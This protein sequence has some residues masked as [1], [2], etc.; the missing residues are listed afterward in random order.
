MRYTPAI[1]F[2]LE[3]GRALAKYGVPAHR[4]EDTM[5]LAARHFGVKGEFFSTPTSIMATFRSDDDASTSVL[6]V[7]DSDVDLAKMIALD[8][9]VENLGAREGPEA[10]LARVREIDE[11]PVPYRRSLTVVSFGLV[12]G[13]AA[14]FFGGG[15]AEVGVATGIGVVIGLM[16]LLVRKLPAGSRGFDLV[17]AFVASM[18]AASVSH[19]I[20]PIAAYVATLAGLI[21]LIPGLTLTTAMSELATRNLVSGAARLTAAAIVFL[22]LIFGVALA[23]RIETLIWGASVAATATP[24]PPWT[25]FVALLVCCAGLVVLFRAPMSAAPGILLAAGLGLAGARWGG[26]TLG[27]DIGIFVGAYLV[28]VTANVYARLA[29]RPSAVLMLPGLLLLV[30]GSIGFRSLAEL[31]ERD[32]LAGVSSAFATVLAAVSIVAGLLMANITVRPKRLL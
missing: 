18:I 32:P 30:P 29:K 27:G 9:L 19:L 5:A 3:L 4:L 11:A 20:S 23:A 17:A 7:H 8:E 15:L 28:C 26:A 12:S 10:A 24:L 21:V 13:A 2:V 31:L 14:R 1:E 22:Q 16:S 6:R 25:F